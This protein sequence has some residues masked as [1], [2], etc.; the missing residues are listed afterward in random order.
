VNRAHNCR[1]EHTEQAAR[2]FYLGGTHRRSG[3]AVSI[4]CDVLQR[5]VFVN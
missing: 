4:L 3:M 2:K 5:H 1:N